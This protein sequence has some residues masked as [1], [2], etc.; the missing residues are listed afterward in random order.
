[1]FPRTLLLLALV[2]C[3]ACSGILG[4]LGINNATL[5]LPLPRS[6]RSIPD[7]YN[8]LDDG[9]GLAGLQVELRGAIT[10]TFTAEDFPVAPF[11]VPGSGRVFVEVSLLFNGEPRASGPIAEGQAQ[12]V[13]ESDREW[14]LRFRRS[15]TPPAPYFPTN[16]NDPDEIPD[17]CSWPTCREYRRFGIAPRFRNYEE[18]ALWM[19]LLAS[20]HCPEGEVCN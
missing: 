16:P 20:I 1:M 15:E 14:T 12:W 9:H 3:T 13:L 18:E 2:A 5:E 4:F 10:R 6:H 7:E 8:S 19:V 11:S 17:Y